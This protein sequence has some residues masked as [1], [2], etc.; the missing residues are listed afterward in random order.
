MS[1][2]GPGYYTT[3]DDKPLVERGYIARFTN[4]RLQEIKV[5]SSTDGDVND[6]KHIS[7]ADWAKGAKANAV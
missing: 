5:E 6:R 2:C 3:R 4:G 7:R 1:G